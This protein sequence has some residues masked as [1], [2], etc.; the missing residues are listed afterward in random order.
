MRSFSLKSEEAEAALMDTWESFFREKSK[1]RSRHRTRER[2]VK[3]AI[4]LLLFGSIAMAIYLG[5]AGV[6]R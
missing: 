2:A 1:R 6:P 5:V 3:G 4:L